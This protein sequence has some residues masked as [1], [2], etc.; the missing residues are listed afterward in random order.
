M[1]TVMTGN[2]NKRKTLGLKSLKFQNS[3]LQYIHVCVLS[4]WNITSE[5]NNSQDYNSLLML[6]NQ[7]WKGTFILQS[8]INEWGDRKED[9]IQHSS[10]SRGIH[11]DQSLC[12]G[13]SP[14][15]PSLLSLCFHN[16]WRAD[17][18]IQGSLVSILQKKMA[19]P[20]PQ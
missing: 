1:S 16:W 7:T 4:N 11:S 3:T 6:I 5:S 12:T 20:P 9:C 10:N 18:V 15:A 13:S 2:G 8:S 14:I 17:Q 19:I